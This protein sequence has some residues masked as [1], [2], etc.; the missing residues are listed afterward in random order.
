MKAELDQADWDELFGTGTTN[1]Q[2]LG[3]VKIY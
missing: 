3:F 1:D 2:C